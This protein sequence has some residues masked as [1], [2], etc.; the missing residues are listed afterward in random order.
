M[1][2]LRL[3]ICLILNSSRRFC[4][5]LVVIDDIWL[6]QVSLL[7]NVTPRSLVVSFSSVTSIE[8]EKV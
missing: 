2:V 1:A 7:L 6:P 5:T 3:N 8:C 4:I